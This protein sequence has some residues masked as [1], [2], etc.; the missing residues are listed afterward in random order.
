M[1]NINNHLW[2]ELTFEDI[3][4][5]IS[6]GDE[7]N[8]FFEYKDDRV[9]SEKLMKEISAFANTYGGYIFLGVS[10]DKK[11]IGCQDWN[12]E[13][14]NSVIHDSITPIP[15]FDIRKFES[16][17][18]KIV[19]VIKI[20]EGIDPPYI[21]NRGKIFERVS[22]GSYVI[23]DSSKLTQL[24]YKKQENDKRIL[25]KITIEDINDSLIPRNIYGYL[26]MGFSLNTSNLSKI[27]HYLFNTDFQRIADYIKG[28]S[29]QFSISKLAN[30]ILIS[31]GK[32]E[33]SDGISAL[34]SNLHNFMEIKADGSVK[35]RIIF[36]SVDNNHKV[37]IS[38][39]TSNIIYFKN[40]YQI[41]LGD[42][43]SDY[44][45]SASKYEKL[46]V[47]KQFTPCYNDD[48]P[49]LCDTLNYHREKYGNNLI[50]TGNRIP[51]SGLEVIDR[52]CFDNYDIE[53]NCENLISALFNLRHLFLGFVD[54]PEQQND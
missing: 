17:Q 41:L 25:Q 21:T 29:N 7:E 5:Q 4:R 26:D 8:F 43:L 28:I 36:N 18:N 6:L 47:L 30:S 23:N 24:F 15:V 9:S 49:V 14:I 11:I 51:S 22:S 1:V 27:N 19:L 42:V 31:I 54:F 2:N 40:I 34:P 20:E 33:I 50:I 32:A 45:I 35:L 12:E 10:D 44:F 16:P 53:Y 37:D 3:E 46:T 48:I 52:C 39:L 13:R 38:F